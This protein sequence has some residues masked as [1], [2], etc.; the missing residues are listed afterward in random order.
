MSVVST[1][2]RHGD[3]TIQ[4]SGERRG[5]VQVAF[6]DGRVVDRNY[7]TADEP[8]WDAAV[9]SAGAQVQQDV[10][11]RDAQEAVDKDVDITGDYGE[12]TKDQ[13]AA[14][15]LYRAY[16]T[17]DPYT[18]YKK[19]TKFNEWRIR[20]GLSVEEVRLRFLAAGFEER[21]WD[22]M[23]ERYQYLADPARVTIMEDH[24]SVV[25]GDTWVTR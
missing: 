23:I 4:V 8:S 14:A 11:R 2:V 6:T 12:S 1:T 16:T 25:A 20:D 13:Q 19:Y 15:Y 21:T 5:S 17:P 9:A 18:A 7:R 22:L 24:Q 3:P 10:A